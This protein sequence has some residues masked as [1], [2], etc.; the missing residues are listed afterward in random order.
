M[1]LHPINLSNIFIIINFQT[2]IM[3]KSV[4]IC[5]FFLTLG[6]ASS[7]EVETIH[8]TKNSELNEIEYLSLSEFLNAPIE[9]LY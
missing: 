3:K 7:T 6:Y 2:L 9:E 4:I 1:Q 8:Q 5:C